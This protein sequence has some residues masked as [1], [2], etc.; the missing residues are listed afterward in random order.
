MNTIRVSDL[1]FSYGGSNP[2]ISDITFTIDQPG[3]YCILG[4]N[5]VGKSTLIKCLN[6]INN[7]S[8]GIVE[9]DGHDISKMSSKELSKLVGYVPVSG[10]DV[11]SMPVIDAVLIGRY[12]QQKWKTTEEDLIMVK[13]AMKLLGISS[14]ALRGYNELSAGQHQKVAIARGLVQ[15]TPILLLDEPT[16]NLD[17]RYQVY[18]AELLKGLTK[19]TDMTVIMISHDLNITAKYADKIILMAPPGK[20]RQIGTPEEVIT[21]E[22]IKEVY[23]VDCEI[24]HDSEGKPHVILSSALWIDE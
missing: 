16:A 17:V 11:F 23:G 2:V 8:S 14:L 5:G 3:L 9:I 21:K 13:K 6:K 22:T 15:E 7:P 18:I 1:S 20:I 10:N 4:P 19:M 24:V 12:T